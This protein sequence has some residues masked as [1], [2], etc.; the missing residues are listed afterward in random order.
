MKHR[1]GIVCVLVAIASCAFADAADRAR[2]ELDALRR[3]RRRDMGPAQ[4]LADK[5]MRDVEAE[6]QRIARREVEIA[7]QYRTEAAQIYLD[8]ERAAGRDPR[9]LERERAKQ[10]DAERHKLGEVADPSAAER[11]ADSEAR[12]LARSRTAAPAKQ[13]GSGRG[14]QLRRAEQRAIDDAETL[15]IRE[16]Q[17]RDQLVRRVLNAARELDREAPAAA[18]LPKPRKAAK[19]GKTWLDKLFPFSDLFDHEGRRD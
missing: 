19:E 16:K 15:V 17:R 9:E 3:A 11:R 18:G 13:P 7:R 8:R 6:H 4:R 2:Q 5:A 1:F 10:L 12:R 14:G